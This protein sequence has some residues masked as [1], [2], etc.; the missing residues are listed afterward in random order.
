MKLFFLDSFSLPDVLTNYALRMRN[1][2]RGLF[3]LENAI[4]ERAYWIQQMA[5][6]CT[7]K[8]VTVLLQFDEQFVAVASQKC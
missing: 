3:I 2:S 5:Y 7:I 4:G 8:I 1:H 6:L